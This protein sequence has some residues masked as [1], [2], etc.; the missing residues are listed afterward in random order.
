MIRASLHLSLSAI[1]DWQLTINRVTID[2]AYDPIVANLSGADS[3]V[4]D[5]ITK[6]IDAF[7]HWKDQYEILDINVPANL[8]P[9]SGTNSPTNIQSPPY[10]NLEEQCRLLLCYLCDNFISISKAQS[11]VLIGIGSA[12]PAIHQLLLNR[13]CREKVD[14]VVGFLNDKAQLKILK[15]HSDEYLSSWYRNIA[16]LWVDGANPAWD[17]GD[18]ERRISKGRYGKV[19]K[20]DSNTLTSESVRNEVVEFVTGIVNGNEEQMSE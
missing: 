19:T 16:K 2:P 20:G 4:K 13:E 12:F 17:G 15:S 11:V 18:A 5:P 10:S 6:Y 14:C 3:G 7:R 1:R 9:I 8:P